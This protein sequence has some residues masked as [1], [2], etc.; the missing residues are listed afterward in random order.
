MSKLYNFKIKYKLAIGFSIMIIFIIFIG[1]TGYL[2]IKKINENLQNIF[3]GR[4]S[5]LNYLL[6]TDRDL[7]QMLVSERSMLF[8]ENG[9]EIF[10][11]L[12]KAYKENLEESRARWNKYKEL[13]ETSEE[14]D[15]IRKFEESW[16]EWSEYSQRVVDGINSNRPESNSEA[17]TVSLGEA[18]RR[19]ETMRGYIDRLT[20]ISLAL[21]NKTQR[22]SQN[23]YKRAVYTYIIVVL[24]GI[25]IGA[26]LSLIISRKI[27]K[28][29]SRAVQGLKVISQGEGDL[30]RRLPVESGDEIGVLSVCFNNFMEKLRE[31]IRN[32][33]ENARLLSGASNRLLDLSTKMSN[34]SNDVSQ[35]AY[36][37]ASAAEQMSNNMGSVSSAM[38][39]ASANVDLVAGSV[40]EMGA[41]V[42]EI[43]QNSERARAV[44]SDA[45]SRTKE[46]SENVALLGKAA[47]EIGKVTETINEISDQTN[48]LALNATIEA[49]RAGE[50]GKG[51][52]VV[53]NEIKELARQTAEATQ[54]I[55]NRIENIQNTTMGTIAGIEDISKVIHE[56]ND[57]VTIIASAV[58]EQSVT[59]SQISTNI[60]QTFM[61]ISEV[62]DNIS[63]STNVS[64]EI[65]RDISDVNQLTGD[66]TN[67]A[68]EIKVSALELYN[69]AEKL[70]STFGKFKI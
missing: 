48:L 64:S 3:S 13:A 16:E 4:M 6:Q 34:N 39:E 33:A 32:V 24:A 35:K 2:N 21:A 62:N 66:I 18:N 14:I 40:E 42:N 69:L 57:I 31:I 46:T 55:K 58:E 52:A 50:A 70:N 49:A 20:D 28:P 44:T 30:T 56:V 65:A 54:Q 61:G 60:N 51:F 12:E 37:V 27:T 8:A 10:K 38:A 7:Q 47:Q 41:T 11:K 25:Y 22:E 19:F 17:R 36:T 59:T 67:S 5:S 15:I 29:I 45:V 43:A 9:S 26:L 63:Q 68:S 1:V 23:T 53:A